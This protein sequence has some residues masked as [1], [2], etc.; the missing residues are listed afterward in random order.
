MNHCNICHEILGF[1]QGYCRRCYVSI[2]S[3]GFS[4]VV[5]TYRGAERLAQLISEAKA[6]ADPAIGA[7][8]P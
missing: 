8:L 3:D 4:A 6:L 1:G 2:Q 7:K 5:L